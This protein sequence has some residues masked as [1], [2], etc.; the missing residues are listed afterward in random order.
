[1][2]S[3]DTQAG[4]ASAAVVFFGHYGDVTRL[5]QQRG[6]CRQALYRQAHAA[7][8]AL[9]G[10]ETQ[11]RLALLQQQLDQ[12]HQ[13]I[14]D[15]RRRL[16]DAVLCDADC[17]AEFT[18]TSQALGVSLLCAR[19]LLG[20]ILR[21]RTPAP[22]TLGRLAQDTE[23][24]IQPILAILDRC[25]RPRALQVAPDEIFSGRKPVLMTVDQESLCWLGGRLVKQRHGQEWAQEFRQLPALEQR[26][27]QERCQQHPRHHE[28]HQDDHRKRPA[29]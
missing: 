5:A 8:R 1:M 3:L 23:Q 14:D 10:T 11:Q 6:T 26:H 19:V 17:Q 29:A 18:A 4:L 12:A 28:A 25:S 13:E 20:V 16:A 15:L 2:Y 21:R 24:Q 9:E 27:F 7:A 22:A